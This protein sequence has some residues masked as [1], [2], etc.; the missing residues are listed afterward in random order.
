MLRY[1][2]ELRAVFT[3][4]FSRF[5]ILRLAADIHDLPVR[6]DQ[7]TGGISALPVTWTI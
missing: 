7:L 4:L 1:A 6:G 5:P 3:G 2:H